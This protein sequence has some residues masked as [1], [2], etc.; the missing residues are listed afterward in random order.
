MH[1]FL[2][3]LTHKYE[4]AKDFRERTLAKKRESDDTKWMLEVGTPVSIQ[5]Q[6]GNNP[7]KW[8][9]TGVILENKPHSQVLIRVDGSRRVT[10]RNR[11]FVRPLDPRI[12]PHKSPRIVQK[13]RSD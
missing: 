6:S 12:K 10:T 11:R 9:K 4:P 5:N 7:N 1:D 8:D 13:K 3:N 2:P